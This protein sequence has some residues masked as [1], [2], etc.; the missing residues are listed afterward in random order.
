[1]SHSGQN[2]TGDDAP[3]RLVDDAR[4][5]G[6]R[7]ATGDFDWIVFDFDGT[8]YPSTAG[9]ESQ[10]APLMREEIARALGISTAEVPALRKKLYSLTGLK[11][12]AIGLQRHHGVDPHHL[13]YRVYTRLDITRLAPY[14]GFAERLRSLAAVTKLCLLTNSYQ[15]FIAKALGILGLEHAFHMVITTGTN[16]FLRKPNPEVFKALFAVHLKTEPARVALFD[17]IASSQRVVAAMGAVTVLVG[18]GLRPSPSFVDLHTNEEWTN[19]PD[20]VDYAAH[21]ITA[22][23]GSVLESLP[24][25]E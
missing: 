11:E 3:G 5:F 15:P 18:N 14:P 24:P 13:Y 12:T 10:L 7:V 23:L 22:F 17:D 21:D 9:I 4:A 8:C 25:H 6:Q 16:G 19:K 2:T 1:V 20:F